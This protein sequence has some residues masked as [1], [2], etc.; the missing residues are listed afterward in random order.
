RQQP[1]AGGGPAKKAPSRIPAT[2][3]L[4]TKT[5]STSLARD[6]KEPQSPTKPAPANGKRA[7][8]I[9]S[10][11]STMS[12][13]T[14]SNFLNPQ[15]RRR[16]KSGVFDASAAAAG[17]RDAAEPQ[18]EAGVSS[19]AATISAAATKGRV[20]VGRIGPERHYLNRA[21]LGG[22]DE[23]RSGVLATSAAAGAAGRPRRMTHQATKLSIDPERARAAG[24]AAGKRVPATATETG[25]A[26][27]RRFLRTPSNH[28]LRKSGSSEKEAVNDSDTRAAAAR[29]QA[30]GSATFGGGHRPLQAK[31]ETSAKAGR[32]DAEHTRAAPRAGRPSIGAVGTRLPTWRTQ[33]AVRES[34]ER[35]P[36]GSSTPQRTSGSHASSGT[37]LAVRESSS[38]EKSSDDARERSQLRAQK[39]VQARAAQTGRTGAAPS[40][41]VSA[42]GIGSYNA[43]GYQAG[44]VAGRAGPAASVVGA[45]APSQP[46]ATL[47]QQHQN[48]QHQNQQ[49]QNQQQQ[50]QNQ[51][52]H[53]GVRTQVANYQQRF[54]GPS[55][56]V[57]AA[58]ATGQQSMHPHYGAGKGGVAAQAP[59]AA[60]AHSSGR[61]SAATAAAAGG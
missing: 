58:P 31:L 41:S 25:P 60:S 37:K 42:I 12:R 21:A 33:Q 2:A 39:P 18:A 23:E 26:G 11:A 6:A 44:R 50:N 45:I 29:P 40:S 4:G 34:D 54:G 20:G 3:R 61:A 51:Q 46:S 53:T 48:Q 16:S 15:L 24:A 7:Q 19:G 43:S 36:S 57:S 1:E 49:H 5:S 10:K 30:R 55:S 28:D 9:T 47:L 14:A 52:Q 22:A 8:N 32:A 56:V 59:R 38:Q 35:G 13:A 17:D 27:G